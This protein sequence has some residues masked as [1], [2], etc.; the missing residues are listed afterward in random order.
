MILFNIPYVDLF[1]F[2]FTGYRRISFYNSPLTDRIRKRKAFAD[3]ELNS[4]SIPL[5]TTLSPHHQFSSF[6]AATNYSQFIQ[7]ARNLYSFYP[8][9]KLSPTPMLCQTNSCDYTTSGQQTSCYSP[10][11]EASNTSDY[12]MTV[13]TTSTTT[14]DI[15]MPAVENDKRAVKLSFSIESIIGIK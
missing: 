8:Q 11:S 7:N 13:L 9:H 6:N 12:E 3:T 14:T 15:D 4:S 5:P 2:C 10:N 1:F